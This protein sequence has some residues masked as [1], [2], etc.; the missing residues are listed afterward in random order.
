MPQDRTGSSSSHL[1]QAGADDCL[2]AE[3]PLLDNSRSKCSTVSHSDGDSL[4]LSISK[5]QTRLCYY[6]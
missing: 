5:V 1:G 4:N 3:Q 2:K 6:S